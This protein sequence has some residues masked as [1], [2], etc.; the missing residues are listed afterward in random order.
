MIYGIQILNPLYVRSARI[1][2]INHPYSQ[3]PE[4]PAKQA[5]LACRVKKCDFPLKSPCKKCKDDPQRIL[6]YLSAISGQTI[7]PGKTFIFLDEIQEEPLGLTSLKHFCENARENKKFTYSVMKKGARARDY[8]MAITWLKDAG[9][10]YPVTKVNQFSKPLNFHEDP[11][12][13]KLYTL[14]LGLLGAMAQADQYS[15]VSD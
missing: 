11:D 4:H 8:D 15:A 2:S 9:L 14:D 10:V 1:P 13:F 12:A 6:R 3:R 7:V 5:G